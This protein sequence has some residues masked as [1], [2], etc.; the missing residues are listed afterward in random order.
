[1]AD[2]SK[3][4]SGA[5]LLTLIAR[6]QELTLRMARLELHQKAQRTLALLQAHAKPNG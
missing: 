4:S 2:A 3:W 5:N 1:M 6:L